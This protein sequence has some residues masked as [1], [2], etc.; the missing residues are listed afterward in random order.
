MGVLRGAGPCSASHPH[1]RVL[2][3]PLHKPPLG[4]AGPSVVAPMVRPLMAWLRGEVQS[5]SAGEDLAMVRSWVATGTQ[6]AQHL[7]FCRGSLLES[8][9]AVP[10]CG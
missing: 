2:C 10:T 5:R 9:S 4:M 6:G 8:W 1:T 3:S 7:L